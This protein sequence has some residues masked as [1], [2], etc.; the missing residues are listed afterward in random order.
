M[1]LKKPLI[2]NNVLP[3]QINYHLLKCAS[4]KNYG[5]GYEGTGVCQLDSCIDPTLPHMGMSY[6]VSD[7]KTEMKDFLDDFL[8]LYTYHISCTVIE[9]LKID[10]FSI[11]RS[12]WN[13]YYK[14]QEGIG[15][16]DHSED[17]YI[18]LVYTPLTTDGGTEI[19]G[20]VYPD[21]ARQVKVF[22]SNWMHKGICVKEKKARF[23][24]NIILKL[25][26]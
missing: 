20:Q 9:K 6:H 13:Y 22:K 17:N 14:D 24:L 25:Y 16:I 23:S 11:Y 3:E 15:H 19:L 7:D 1:D 21:I 18:S 4:T 26:G 5:F 12:V 2:I 8:K 10:K